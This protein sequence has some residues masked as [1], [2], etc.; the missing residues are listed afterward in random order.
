MQ[1][2]T[3]F[4]GVVAD[5]HTTSAGRV[6]FSGCKYLEGLTSV[7]NLTPLIIPAFGEREMDRLLDRLDGIMLTGSRANV[8]PTHYNH[9]E[10]PEHGPFDDARDATSLPL[11][12]AAVDKG[13]PL[14]AICRGFQ[15]LNVAL[16]GTLTPA[17]HKIEGRLDHS[18]P[19]T[20]DFDIRHSPRHKVRLTKGGL[21]EN[22]LG[23]SEIQVNSLHFQAVDD[24]APRLQVEA[25]AEDGTIE[26]VVVPDTQGFIVGVQWHPEYKPAQSPFSRAFY[27]AFEEAVH[28]R[29]HAKA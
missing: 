19:Q 2:E 17:V 29:R 20:D 15:E 8:R 5:T 4:I 9:N 10:T 24:L 16:G 1:Q 22:W 14:I 27:G 21:F 23:T 6:F 3:A 12:R 7:T 18:E 13:V 11:I 26:G 25:I 28:A